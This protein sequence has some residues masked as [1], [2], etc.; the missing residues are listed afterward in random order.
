MER[1][2]EALL[3]PKSR[4]EDAEEEDADDPEFVSL[5]YSFEICLDLWRAWQDFGVMP[6][7]GGYFDQPRAW[8]RMIQLFNARF[9]VARRAQQDGKNDLQ[10]LLAA[11]AGADD[12][13]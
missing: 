13:I 6:V 11:S 5:P 7:S 2:A 12:L 9:D 1:H 3:N 10:E 8:R 4:D